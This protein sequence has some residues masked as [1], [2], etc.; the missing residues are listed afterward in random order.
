MESDFSAL[1]ESSLYKGQLEEVKESLALKNIINP[2]DTKHILLG[3]AVFPVCSP[4]PLALPLFLQGYLSPEGKDLTE[5]SCLVLRVPRSLTPHIFPAVSICSHLLQE[6]DS[7]D[8]WALS[9]ALTYESSRILLG[10][11]FTAACALSTVVLN[12]PN[13]ATLG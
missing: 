10:V 1:P 13:T 9:K 5:A 4:F 6:E 12:L 7:H 8:G 11:I 2:I 3:L